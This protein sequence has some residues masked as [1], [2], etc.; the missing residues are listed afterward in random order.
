MDSRLL[1]A[2]MTVRGRIFRGAAVCGV[3]HEYGLLIDDQRTLRATIPLEEGTGSNRWE[4]AEA[5]Q[6]LDETCQLGF[7]GHRH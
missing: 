6:G 4:I 1:L 3:R 5:L 7:F 2:G